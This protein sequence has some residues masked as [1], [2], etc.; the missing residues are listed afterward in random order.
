MF[1][2]AIPR[3]TFFCSAVAKKNRKTCIL[4]RCS[5][6]LTDLRSL[7]CKQVQ[8]TTNFKSQ[9][10]KKIYKMFHNVKCASSYVLYLMECI[11][12][13]KQYVGK[14]ETC[15]N[16]RLNNHRKDVKKVDAIM[17]WK[18]FQQENHSFS[19]HAKLNI[20]D[21]LRNTSKS[22]ATLTQRLIER[23]NSWS[24]KLDTLYWKSFNMGQRQ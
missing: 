15:F 1:F 13:N 7:C 8:K 24:L 14:S 20:I 6:C 10:T 18:Q 21:H 11:L 4:G 23:E 12:C 3:N 19:K 22:T 16:I 9:Q 5:P 17:T 2:V